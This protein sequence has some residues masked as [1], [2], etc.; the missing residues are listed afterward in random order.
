TPLVADLVAS[1]VCFSFAHLDNMGNLSRT[2][3]RDAGQGTWQLR[4][5]AKHRGAGRGTDSLSQNS[6]QTRRLDDQ[7]GTIP[8]FARRP[9]AG[10]GAGRHRFLAG[11][12]ATC[13]V[14]PC[15]IG[16]RV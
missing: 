5:T 8:Q 15:L 3:P 11:R 2:P 4:S 1:M 16:D 7:T 12:G 10:T 13:A 6:H 14:Q 9:A